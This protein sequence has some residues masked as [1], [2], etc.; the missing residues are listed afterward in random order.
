MTWI[1]QDECYVET[2]YGMRDMRY[3]EIEIRLGCNKQ[4]EVNTVYELHV[5]IKLINRKAA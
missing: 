2:W 3:I 1:R 4:N 5:M